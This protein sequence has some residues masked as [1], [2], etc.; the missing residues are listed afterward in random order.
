MVVRYGSTGPN[1]ILG[2][3]GNDTLYG[4]AQGGN[5]S[6]TSG[7]DTLTGG[8]GNDKLFG[9]TA[10]DSLIGGTGNDSLDGGTGSDKLNGGTGNDIYVINTTS[11]IITEATGA[12]TDTVRSSVT[13]TLGAN[14]EN[15]TLTGTGS[16]NGTGNSLNN[17]VFGNLDSNILTGRDG[18]DTLDGNFGYD[19][20]IGG[21]GN[22]TLQ[23]GPDSDRLSAG[24][25]DDVLIGYWPGSPQPPGFGEYDTLVGG[26]GGDVFFL[27]DSLGGVAYSSYEDYGYDYGYAIITDFDYS[28]GDKFQVSGTDYILS[29]GDY[30]IGTSNSDTAIYYNNNDLIAIVQ[31]TTNVLFPDDFISV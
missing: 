9:G 21:N 8:A 1:N 14:L 29:Y 6:S 27:G 12:G 18:N 19:T 4:W 7:N 25:G 28:E 15:L 26:A 13:Y 16:I 3:S 5:A 10:N 22:D 31:D 17:I 23:G 30:G 2:T 24:A 20:L 11:D